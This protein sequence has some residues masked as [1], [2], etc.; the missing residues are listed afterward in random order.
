MTGGFIRYAPAAGPSRWLLIAGRR[1][2]AAVESTVSD[3]IV[4][5]LFW[6]ADSDL[7][8]IESVVGAFPLAGPDSVRSFA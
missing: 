7:A 6:L 4:D 3:E 5:A 8:T 2:V 1:F